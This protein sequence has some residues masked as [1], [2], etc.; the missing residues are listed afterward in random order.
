MATSLTASLAV[1][2][3][4]QF[5]NPLD[6]GAVSYPV[7]YSPSYVLTDGTGA[8]QAKSVFVDTRTL[9]AS[10]T[11]DIDLSG[12]LLDAFGTAILFTKIKAL[13]ISADATNV[14]DVV[15]GGASANQ[16]FP[17]FGA[18]TERVKV[19]PGG[20]VAFIAPDVNGYAITAGTADLLKILNSAGGTSV[21]Y[22]IAIVGV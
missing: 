18:A 20:V 19:K 15:V 12:V 16:A 5:S 22:T 21:I 4:A 14:N 11:E 3:T 9:T 7:Q 2:L 6:V 1:N 8:N 13:I 10:A 17:F